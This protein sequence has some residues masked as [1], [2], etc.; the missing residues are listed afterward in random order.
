[1]HLV[2]RRNFLAGLGLGAGAHLLGSMFRSMLPEALGAVATKKRL[3]IYGNS[4][5]VPA[6]WIPQAGPGGTIAN[7]GF[8]TGLEP[9]KS[10]MLVLTKLNNPFD[11]GQHRNRSALSVVG[12]KGGIGDTTAV[13]APT[14]LS[15]D[16]LIARRIGASDAH[17]SINLTPSPGPNPFYGWSSDGP[18]KVF[19]V[20]KD[21]WR[22]YQSI[23]GGFKPGGG[24]DLEKHLAKNRSLLSF[25]REDIGRMNARL[26]ST[27]RQKLDQYLDSIQGMETRLQALKD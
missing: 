7:L 2:R 22:A 20:E 12:K 24:A 6:R 10:D 11:L 25:L 18:G 16:R 15:I 9:Y 5:S 21:A 27:E 14:D 4:Q 3:L 23:F 26:G 1:M 17:P 19:P 8:F 13:L